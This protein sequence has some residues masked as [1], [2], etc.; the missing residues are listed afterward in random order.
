MN[1]VDKQMDQTNNNKSVLDI[2]NE[3]IDGDSPETKSMK[4]LIA[5]VSQT[6]STALVLGET[7]T[8][9]DVVAQAIHKCSKKKGALVTVNCAA[10][11]SELLESELFGHEK[12]SFTGADKQRKGRFEQSSGGSLFLD[13]IGDMP[14]PLQ[15]KLLRAIES[16]TIQRVG[17]AE[18]IKIDLR[19]ICAT[20]RDLEKKVESGEF[21]AD[22]YFRIN[23]LPINVPSLAER[24]TDIPD[25]YNKLL[26]N[27]NLS[28]EMQPIFSPEAIT[29]LSKHN[30]PGNVREL[31]NVIER[32]CIIFP[33]KEVTSSN[34]F[35]NLLRLKVPTLAEEKNAIWEM[36]ADLSGVNHID[37]DDKLD[38]PE[39]YLPHPK[40]YK[41]WFTFYDEIDLRRHL[42]DVEI[43]LI[44]QALEKTGNKIANAADKLK[45][46]RTTLIEK[47]KKYSITKII[48]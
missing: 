11:P 45:L 42:Q 30:W 15:A 9:K 18:D 41:N 12:G 47:M 37:I 33:G 25:L 40:N 48:E 7:G 22:L 27:L 36:T 21:R 31:K 13:E 10:I 38:S 17:G 39:D 3:M 46:R 29:A 5:M 20:H 16:R 24:R 28:R 32:A 19:L 44:E 4:K 43:V 1:V 6:D 8:G 26:K 2:L 14:L 23:V 34:V 35:E